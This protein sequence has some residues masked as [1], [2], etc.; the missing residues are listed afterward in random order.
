MRFLAL[1][2]LI[3][4]AACSAPTPPATDTPTR[5]VSLDYCADQYV[6]KLAER[7]HI[8]AVSPDAD[9][10][11]SY[12]REAAAGLKQVRPLAEDI[13]ARRPDLIV[14][15]YGGG[16]NA[17][18]FFERAGIPVL[19]I[20]F[21][22]T[23]ADI[24]TMTR[25]VAAGLGAE[26]EG[27]ALLTEM[28]NRLA[29]LAPAADGPA[30]LYMTPGGVTSGPGSLVADMMSRAGLTNFETRPGWHA[31]PLERLARDTPDRIAASFYSDTALAGTSWS[32]ARHPIARA[33]TETVPTVRLEGAWTSCGAWFLLD[34]IEA[35]ARDPTP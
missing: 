13:L 12:M 21:T 35:L 23:V 10:S 29:A 1:S 18:T 6:L 3:G 4:A 17:A 26:A 11:F 8:L 22:N 9:A 19:Q 24:E 20:G 14:R 34:A 27:E 31:L 33:Q 16:P 2:C 30:T 32:A 5:I 7:D 15:S 25:D 28:A